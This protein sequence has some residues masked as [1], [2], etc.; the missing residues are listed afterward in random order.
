M[1]KITG[2]LQNRDFI[3][4]L[5]LAAGLL[6]PQASAWSRNLTLPALALVM[7]MSMIGLPGDFLRSPRSLLTP[8]IL[9]VLMSYAILGGFILG[10]SALLIHDGELWNGFIILAIMPPA[11]AVIPF[12]DLLKGNS[13][14]SLAGTVGGYL[15]AL[16]ILPLTLYNVLGSGQFAL[17]RLSIAAVVLIALPIVLSRT[18][19]RGKIA[20]SLLP[21][22]GTIINW[23]FF[24]VVYTIVGLNQ[25]IFT[26]QPLRLLPVAAIAIGSMFVLG[27]IIEWIGKLLRIDPRT[28]MSLV[29]LGT[30][31]NYGL[32][33]GIALA[34]FSR[35]SAL[36]AT[37]STIFM[38]VYIIWMGFRQRWSR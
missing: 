3:L 37:V 25:E 34:L 7:S 21:L 16:I 30:I 17:G 18:L 22:K 8:A 24:V 19:L 9:G 2:L 26:H 29:L 20:A 23:G 1:R 10:L 14:F 35:E 33:A 31:K 12:T 38:F 28:T 27:L 5:A 32:A 13:A 36:P 6:L 4:F 15:G 11:V